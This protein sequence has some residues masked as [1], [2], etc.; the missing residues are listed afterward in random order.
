[1]TPPDRKAWIG[2]AGWALLCYGAALFAGRIPVGEWYAG[3]AKPAWTPP[4][5]VFA[6]VWTVL[7][8]MM[9]AA[10]WLVWKGR[11]FSGA[12]LALALF[13]AQL[14]LNVAWTWLF[15][16]L[17]RPGLA[18]VDIALL[19]AAILATVLAFWRFRRLAGVLL[20]PYLAWVTFAAALNLE[21]WRLN[22]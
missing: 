19:W 13:G 9:A 14:G 18:A 6:P 4:G 5:W 11:G 22:A 3:L 12:R 20:V 1:M 8:G 17:Q 10:A 21:I 16:G 15:F 2:L 7:Y